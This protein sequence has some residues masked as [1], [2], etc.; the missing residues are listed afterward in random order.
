M[1]SWSNISAVPGDG[2]DLLA[3]GEIIDYKAVVYILLYNRITGE[4]T[5]PS[6]LAA[7]WRIA[8]ED[9]RIAST[10]ELLRISAVQMLIL[11]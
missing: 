8:M 3:L 1:S 6:R 11:F 4:L 2:A 9:S 7:A 10:L 5:W